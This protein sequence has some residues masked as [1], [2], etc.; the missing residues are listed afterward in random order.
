MTR[1]MTMARTYR[2]SF[3]DVVTKQ[4]KHEHPERT[5]YRVSSDIAG[6]YTF[7]VWSSRESML[8]AIRMQ[9]KRAPR[10]NDWKTLI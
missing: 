2:A 7:K 9:E 4:V 5:S 10:S 3:A 6:D 8:L 1:Q